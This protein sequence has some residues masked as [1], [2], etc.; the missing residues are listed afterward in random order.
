MVKEHDLDVITSTARE[1]H[2]LIETLY[3][4]E[5]GTLC[6]R[7]LLPTAIRA[8]FNTVKSFG[9]F[10][11]DQSYLPAN[12]AI[13]INDVADKIDSFGNYTTAQS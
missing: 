9:I 12:D 1:H 7:E 5:I 3:T 13:S 8:R 11:V 10:E 2:Q 6:E 4:V